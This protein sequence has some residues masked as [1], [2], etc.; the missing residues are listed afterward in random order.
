MEDHDETWTLWACIH[1]MDSTA[2]TGR[3]LEKVIAP[4]EYG[5]WI[6]LVSKNGVERATLIENERWF[7]QTKGMVLAVS[8]MVEKLGLLGIGQAADNILEGNYILSV[9]TKAELVNILDHL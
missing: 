4:D 2:R 7:T 6:D 1:L 5:E 8:P 3:G 9:G